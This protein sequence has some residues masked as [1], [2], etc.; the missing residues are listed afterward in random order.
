MA[1]HL[2]EIFPEG[3]IIGFRHNNL[4]IGDPAHAKKIEAPKLAVAKAAA[5]STARAEGDLD[6][7]I[8][9]YLTQINWDLPSSLWAYGPL[10]AQLNPPVTYT[11]DYFSTPYTTMIDMFVPDY[12]ERECFSPHFTHQATLMDV[13]VQANAVN[14]PVP[15]PPDPLIAPYITNLQYTS[16]SQPQKNTIYDYLVGFS[17]HNSA[18]S[19]ATLYY[20]NSTYSDPRQEPDGHWYIDYTGSDWLYFIG[21]PQSQPFAYSGTHGSA[22]PKL[23]LDEFPVGAVPLVQNGEGD[24]DARNFTLSYETQSFT[25]RV[26]SATVDGETVH[27]L[28][29]PDKFK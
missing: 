22:Y 1:K 29:K 15:V 20:S 19:D 10:G 28:I 18:L 23:R 8:N 26:D 9:L 16:D 5:L 21:T 14:L 27:T 4:W 25:F 3:K 13:I 6:Y 11:P 17:F 2:R 12:E 24:Y 7:E